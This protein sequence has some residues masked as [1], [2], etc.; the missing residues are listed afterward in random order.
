MKFNAF[1]Q[2]LRTPDD[3]QGNQNGGGG[4]GGQQGNQGTQGSQGT[5]DGG[6]G[7]GGDG[8]GNQGGQGDQGG[9]DGQGGQAGATKGDVNDT[10][11]PKMF[12][13]NGKLT[14]EWKKSATLAG[15]DLTNVEGKTAEEIL[16]QLGNQNKLIGQKGGIVKVPENF[17]PADPVN[18]AFRQANAIPEDPAAYVFKPGADV[19]QKYGLTEADW[20]EADALGMAK[21]AHKYGLTPAQAKG[22]AQEIQEMQ[23]QAVSRQVTEQQNELHQAEQT[24]RTKWGA[25]HGER[26]ETLKRLF[27]A[28]GHSLDTPG[29]RDPAT[30]MVVHD[31]T[32]MLGATA[33]NALIG[34]KG[35]SGYSSG[36]DEAHAIMTDKNHAD[37]EAYRNGEKHAVDKVNRLLS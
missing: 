10:T 31:I 5:Q 24:L 4:N 2:L 25:A 29:L 36:R 12:D 7:G 19:L 18:V 11:A 35:A 20:S 13:D 27:V 30:L 33:M 15:L 17:D 21:I 37:H 9:G 23:M 26:M 32:T 14:A 34:T 22:A 28:R 6:Q 16:K 3:G 8:G 1:N